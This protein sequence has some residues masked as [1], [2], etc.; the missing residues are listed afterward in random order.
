MYGKWHEGLIG[1][2]EMISIA[3]TVSCLDG[4]IIRAAEAGETV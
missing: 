3:R 2:Y 1:G 4:P